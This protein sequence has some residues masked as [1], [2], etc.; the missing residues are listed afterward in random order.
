MNDVLYGNTQL[1]TSET[2]NYKLCCVNSSNETVSNNDR[3]S[4]RLFENICEVISTT[5][6]CRDRE[7]SYIN[8]PNNLIKENNDHAHSISDSSFQTSV[9]IGFEG[10]P[11][12]I[13]ARV[14]SVLDDKFNVR[15]NHEIDTS[16]DITPNT[17]V[18]S[19]I[20]V[21]SVA[22]ISNDAIFDTHSN[23]EISATLNASV[24]SDSSLDRSTN[25]NYESDAS[26]VV[27]ISNNVTMDATVL[28]EHTYSMPDNT[29]SIKVVCINVCGLLSKLRYPDF[30]EF[31]QSYDIVCLVESKLG[32]L[33]SFEIQ[34]FEILHLLNRK[35]AKS[36]SG[37]IAVL[38]KDT[39]FEHVKILNS[40]SEN[41]LWFTVNN[42]LFHELVLFG[43]IYI[44]PESSSYSNISIFDSIEND[45]ISLNPENNHKIC[46]LGD[47]NAH[48]SNAEDFQGRRRFLKSGT[49]I[50]RHRRYATRT[51]GTNRGRA[52]EGGC[53]PFS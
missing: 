32:F 53:S 52:R 28:N 21:T 11:V 2:P 19:E 49:A 12:N 6:L 34:N 45:I 40:S 35:K 22:N 14:D 38:V 44:P 3:T 43:T 41:V 33:D 37:G 9:G 15:V 48:T 1:H 25:V 8:L 16:N 18:N 36:R 31:C 30:E 17:H 50:E 5:P 7:N 51:E 13:E 39:I 42:S 24:L 26:T 10:Q 23:S 47:F 20:D 27:N 4:N 29:L 46:L